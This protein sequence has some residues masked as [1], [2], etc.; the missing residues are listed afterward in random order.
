MM[1]FQMH[2]EK[3]K[4]KVL[5]STSYTGMILDPLME[6]LLREDA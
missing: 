1:A 3:S 5:T 4:L 6:P 2:M